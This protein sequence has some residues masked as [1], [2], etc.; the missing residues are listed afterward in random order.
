MKDSVFEILF[1]IMIVSILIGLAVLTGI[2]IEKMSKKV[3]PVDNIVIV[4]RCGKKI[5]NEP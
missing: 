1:G 5:I 2:E 4:K 3:S